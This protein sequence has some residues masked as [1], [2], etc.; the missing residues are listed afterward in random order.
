M[1]RQEAK[2]SDPETVDFDCPVC[3]IVCKIIIT[4]FRVDLYKGDKICILANDLL[5]DR[6][7]PECLSKEIAQWNAQ[8]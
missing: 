6:I 4:N 8:N 3:G 1:Y 5:I 7:C 2:N